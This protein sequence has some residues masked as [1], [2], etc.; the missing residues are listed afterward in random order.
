LKKIK[1]SRANISNRN[2]KAFKP[3]V[4]SN[5]GPNEKNAG[6]PSKMKMHITGCKCKKSGCQKKYC[7]CFL[8]GLICNPDRC[9]CENCKNTTEFINKKPK[10][11]DL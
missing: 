9:I 6:S 1:D 8:N 4:L 2:P 11:S 3:K 5:Q 7:E 10:L